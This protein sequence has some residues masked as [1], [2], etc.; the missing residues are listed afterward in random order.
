MAHG[1]PPFLGTLITLGAPLA[2]PTDWTLR[3]LFAWVLPGGIAFAIWRRWCQNTPCGRGWW[4]LLLSGAGWWLIF[5]HGLMA[6]CQQR[7]SPASLLGALVAGSLLIL[8]LMSRR[9]G[10]SPV[11]WLMGLTLLLPGLLFIHRAAGLQQTRDGAAVAAV[12]VVLLALS[13]W[14]GRRV[15]TP[16]RWGLTLVWVIGGWLV[17]L[18]HGFVNPFGRP[19]DPQRIAA[20]DVGEVARA[21]SSESL[22]ESRHRYVFELSG[23]YMRSAVSLGLEVDEK[24][25]GTLTIRSLLAP[26]R[27]RLLSPFT[28]DDYH[29]AVEQRQLTR[30]RVDAIVSAFERHRFWELAS[31]S[32]DEAGESGGRYL[33]ATGFYHGPMW[34]FRALRDGA[35]EQAVVVG[36]H[37]SGSG[38]SETDRAAWQELSQLA[39]QMLQLSEVRLAKIEL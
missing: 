9:A 36:T 25:T 12:A 2:T 4:A 7:E 22:P 5:S 26:S 13:G 33:G 24:G 30:R 1:A 37:F 6:A 39:L 23:V 32:I 20:E 14:I 15:W 31:D 19:K 11:H 28:T 21:L 27:C 18:P 10:H 3:V 34:G 16:K 29:L 35:P 17:V 38:F 8:G